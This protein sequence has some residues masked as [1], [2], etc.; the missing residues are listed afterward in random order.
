MQVKLTKKTAIFVKYAREYGL[1]DVVTK[2]ELDEVAEHYGVNVPQN[3]YVPALGG[4][5][6]SRGKYALPTVAGKVKDSLL[7]KNSV[8]NKKRKSTKKSVRKPVRK[9]RVVAETVEAEDAPRSIKERKS[10]IRIG[11]DTQESFVPSRDDT[12]VRWGND[13]TIRTIIKSEKFFPVWVSGLS[14]NGKT[15]TLEQVC[16]SLGREFFRVNI[17]EETDEDDLLGGFRLVDGDMVWFDGPV[18]SAM[19]RGGVLLLDEIDYGTSKLAC[20]QPV[21]E[22]KGVFLKKINQWVEPKDGFN[23]FATANTKG[24]GDESG[25]FLGANAQNEAFLE[26]FKATIE[27]EYPPVNVEQKILNKVLGD[28]SNESFVKNLTKWAD[29]CR[30]SFASGGVDDVITTRR[31]VHIADAFTIF[32]DEEKAVEIGLSRF[33]ASVKEGFIESYNLVSGKVVVEDEITVEHFTPF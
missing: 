5:R 6:V 23:V 12:Y 27:Q 4:L 30:Q 29:I 11:Q 2:A 8:G 21:L 19:R 22:G 24:Q 17:T 26:R 20:I 9:P 15:F 1:G 7:P 32:G 14:G 33:S 18:V 25:K 28:N 10:S 16:A 13:K 3:L 31:L